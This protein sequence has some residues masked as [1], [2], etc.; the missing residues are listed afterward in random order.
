MTTGEIPRFTVD[1]TVALLRTLEGVH[2]GGGGPDAL[3]RALRTAD[4]AVDGGGDAELVSAA[5]L[6]DIGRAPEVVERYPGMPHEESGARF[7]REHGTERMAFLVERQTAAR[8]Y[9]AA[10]DT[11]SARPRQHE[12]APMT[13]D[14]VVAFCDHPWAGDAARLRRWHDAATHP[15]APTRSLTFFTMVL[16]QVWS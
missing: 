16:R 12:G 5:L 11:D 9:L 14:E 7:C 4:R 6:H 3:V 13:V 15:G 1:D 8:R 2:D 10:V